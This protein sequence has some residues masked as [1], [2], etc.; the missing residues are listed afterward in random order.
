MT[1]KI[2]RSLYIWNKISCIN[3]ILEFYE[4]NFAFEIFKN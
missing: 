3:P 2:L 4:E 1:P